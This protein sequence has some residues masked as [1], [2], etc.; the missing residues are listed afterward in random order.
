MYDLGIP[1]AREIV[2]NSLYVSVGDNNLI[3]SPGRGWRSTRYVEHVGNRWVSRCA[4]A[5]PITPVDYVHQLRSNMNFT[6]RKANL[7]QLQGN[8][9]HFLAATS[10]LNSAQFSFSMTT[11]LV[12]ESTISIQGRRDT[13]Y[14]LHRPVMF[15]FITP[16]KT[17]GDEVC[18]TGPG[19][20]LGGD[21][22]HWQT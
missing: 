20:D 12:L 4:I 14:R 1:R 8:Q 5:S 17:A 10:Y 2:K 13:A 15:F 18:S 7:R 19:V 9:P 3:S 21:P 6:A 11:H 16:G 22:E